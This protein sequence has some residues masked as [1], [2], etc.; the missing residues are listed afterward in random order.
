M[1]VS[2]YRDV[3]EMPPPPRLSS[4]NLG[5]QIRAVWERAHLI[6]PPEIVPGVVRF[7]TIEQSN[8]ARETATLK[9]MRRRTQRDRTA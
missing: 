6:S 4:S 2:K 9:Q 7:R 3:A 5:A 8:E 1:P